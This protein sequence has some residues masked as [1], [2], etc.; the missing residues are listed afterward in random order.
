MDPAMKKVA[1][2]DTVEI[3]S[4][5]SLNDSQT[6]MSHLGTDEKT[7]QFHLVAINKIVELD[8]LVTWFIAK[9]RAFDQDEDLFL[10]IKIVENKADIG[11][12][13]PLDDFNPGYRENLINNDE[14]W[15]FKEP[16]N[17]DWI[18]NDLI[19][20]EVVTLDFYNEIYGE[21]E[22][23][24]D[25]TASGTMY[26]QHYSHRG[27]EFEVALDSD[28]LSVTEYAAESDKTENTRL[29][30]LETG[31]PEDERGGFI[32]VFVGDYLEIDEMMIY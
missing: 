1:F 27:E 6:E 12:F 13:F 16:D 10:F 18:Y 14:F 15:L 7:K 4:V 24:F 31:D 30:F 20:A 28:L 19:F 11:V 2:W 23:E 32:H 5:V 3:G 29:L 21:Y 9:I 25:Q 8:G 26:G 22:M 17:E